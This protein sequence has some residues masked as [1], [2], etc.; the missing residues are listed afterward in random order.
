VGLVGNKK[1]ERILVVDNDKQFADMLVEHLLNLGYWAKAAYTGREGIDRFKKGAF[2]VVITELKMP[3]VDGMDLLEVVKHWD[4]RAE[5]ILITGYGAIESAVKAIKKG[6]CDFIAK[7]VKM[8]DMDV[9]IERALDKYA[10]SKQL[11]L[12]RGVVLMLIISIPFWLIA[13]IA[14]VLLWK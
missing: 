10:R 1:E 14:V 4:K 7:P 13:W 11:G 9:I 6:A 3:D 2:Q 5:V 12:F 8:E